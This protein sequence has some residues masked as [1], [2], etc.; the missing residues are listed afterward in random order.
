MSSTAMKILLHVCGF[1][2]GIQEDAEYLGHRYEDGL[3][4]YFTGPWQ[5]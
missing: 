5:V 1:L 2:L 4:I 3:H